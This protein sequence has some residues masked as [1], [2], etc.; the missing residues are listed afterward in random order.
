MTTSPEKYN[1]G[2]IKTQHI[3]THWSSSVTRIKPPPQP[4]TTQT[5]GQGMGFS[6]GLSAASAKISQATQVYARVML[7]AMRCLSASIASAQSPAAQRQVVIQRSRESLMPSPLHT[8]E[9]TGASG[10]PQRCPEESSQRCSAG[11][12]YEK[13]L[14]NSGAP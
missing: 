12:E 8:A 14:W 1:S 13:R 5:A 11:V 7:A 6:L 4:Q 9:P 10:Q 3:C 2:T